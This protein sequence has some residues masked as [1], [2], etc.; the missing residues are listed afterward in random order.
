[1]V[2]IGR[3]HLVQFHL[4]HLV[5]VPLRGLWFLSDYLLYPFKSLICVVSVPLRGLWFL[6]NRV[7]TVIAK[8]DRN[9]SV[10]LRGLWFLSSCTGRNFIRRPRPFPSPYGDYGS[11][12]LMFPMQVWVETLSFRPLT[13]IMVLIR[14]FLPVN[15][16]NGICFRPLTGIMVLIDGILNREWQ[17]YVTVSVPLRGLWFLSI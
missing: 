5:S 15:T 17:K 8:V 12:Q 14:G 13:G 10:P 4:L 16:R 6:S 3:L 2:L 1:M 7:G 9:V 11:Y